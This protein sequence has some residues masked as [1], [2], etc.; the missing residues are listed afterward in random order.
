MVICS[1]RTFGDTHGISKLWF[2]HQA[3]YDAFDLSLDENAHYFSFYGRRVKKYV[4]YYIPSIQYAFEF[5]VFMNS[6]V[7]LGF[8]IVFGDQARDTQISEQSS[9]RIT[10]AEL[11]F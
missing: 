7:F 6:H 8:P 5:A 10:Y 4:L 11:R 2:E 9:S 3:Q 1:Y